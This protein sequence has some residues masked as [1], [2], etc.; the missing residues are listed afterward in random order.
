MK[1]SPQFED[2]TTF[3]KNLE[4]ELEQLGLTLSG[5]YPLLKVLFYTIETDFEERKATLWYG[6]QQ[7]KLGECDIVASEVAAMLKKWQDE[8][9]RPVDDKT[10][11]QTLYDVATTFAA[12]TGDPVAIDDIL[13]EYVSRKIY[14]T[15]EDARILFAHS[16]FRLKERE[17]DDLQLSLVVATRAYT[18]IRKDFIWVPTDE[19]GGGTYISHIKFRKVLRSV[20]DFKE[21]IRKKVEAGV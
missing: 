10:F 2:K 19:R 18:R 9:E 7:E 16:L 8:I 5:H 17:I 14:Q 3:G 15:K 11:L 20:E 1:D 13:S 21:E 6:P 4:K 12:R